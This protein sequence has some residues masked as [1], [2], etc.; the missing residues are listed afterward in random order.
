M[1]AVYDLLHLVGES[2]GSVTARIIKPLVKN[3]L[4]RAG[5]QSDSEIAVL[6][7]SG[8]DQLLKGLVGAKDK[9]E[10]L[11]AQCKDLL[12]GGMNLTEAMEQ[13][14]TLLETIG[15][16]P[17][18]AK[19]GAL[20]PAL[21]RV[22]AMVGLNPQMPMLKRVSTSL[23][24]LATAQPGQIE[25][26]FAAVCTDIK[27]IT[28]SIA[29]GNPVAVL[30]SV[31]HL[32]GT[33]GV[34]LPEAMQTVLT[35]MLTR[36]LKEL[37]ISDSLVIGICQRTVERKVVEQ[38]GSATAEEFMAN[39]E[40]EQLARSEADTL[41]PLMDALAEAVLSLGTSA[42]IGHAPPFSLDQALKL[43]ELLGVNAQDALLSI[44]SGMYLRKALEAVGVPTTH[45]FQKEARA[46][47][48]QLVHC[49]EA[50]RR[51][52]VAG[53]KSALLG[54]GASVWS[55][56]NPIEPLV[57][58]LAELG[59]STKSM[60]TVMA[61]LLAQALLRATGIPK[62][63]ATMLRVARTARSAVIHAKTL[64]EACEM[65]GVHAVYVA[66]S[67]TTTGAAHGDTGTASSHQRSQVQLSLGSV[68]A[69][70]ASTE[71][72]CS[73]QMHDLQTAA[74]AVVVKLGI[75]MAA[76]HAGLNAAVAELEGLKRAKTKAPDRRFLS[77]LK[78]AETGGTEMQE[79]KWEE[80]PQWEQELKLEQEQEQELPQSAIKTLLPASTV[81][82]MSPLVDA[83][84]EPGLAITEL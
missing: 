19:L 37:D 21:E 5:F 20:Q 73:G 54:V 56:S 16:D 68:A 79:P 24:A 11:M 53:L 81:A 23:Q 70:K 31:F 35:A 22:W 62:G 43:L 58:A 39:A 82:S 51:W 14:P 78:L 65:V 47:A 18:K 25:A 42:G 40:L 72:F 41:Q 27:S 12:D 4:L 30:R 64:D 77:R 33:F 48:L 17:L 75:P 63:H 69:Q 45:G 3:A 32:L 49:T 71:I 9:V 52:K 80:E 6:A 1:S 55:G 50:E 7:A 2:F 10:L 67:A 61:P 15:I 28:G 13:L 8:I 84:G 46:A 36:V 57:A 34:S 44:V 26:K 83:T 66:G 60:A 76:F 38:L 29:E 59:I 74:E